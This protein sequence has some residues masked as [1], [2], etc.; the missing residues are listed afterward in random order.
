MP[1]SGGEFLYSSR[2]G[3]MAQHPTIVE[4]NNIPA[5]SSHHV[6]F[7]RCARCIAL[8]QA[9]GHRYRRKSSVDGQERRSYDGGDNGLIHLESKHSVDETLQRLQ[10]LL[11]RRA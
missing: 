9:H 2:R 7:P 4:N 6:Y 5:I 11:N 1:T 10:E 8:I 3:R